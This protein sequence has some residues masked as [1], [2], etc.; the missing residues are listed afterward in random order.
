MLGPNSASRGVVGRL[1]LLLLLL[2]LP[3][4]APVPAGDEEEEE[5]E[6]CPGAEEVLLGIVGP[7]TDSVMLAPAAVAARMERGNSRSLPTAP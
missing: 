4:L 6:D 1:A 7:L 5:E 2:L 3:L